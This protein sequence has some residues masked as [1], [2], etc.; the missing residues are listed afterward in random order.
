[1]SEEYELISVIM[2]V[3]KEPI[4]WIVKAV[5]SIL[6]QSYSNIELIVVVDNPNNKAAIDYIKQLGTNNIKLLIND[7]NIG[8][9]N[10]LNKALKLC[11]GKYIARM[12]ADDYSYPERIE[13]ELCFL[14]NNRLDIVGCAYE[15]IE[16]DNIIETRSNPRNYEYIRKV[17][18]YKNCMVHPSW[19]VKS[20]VYRD[21]DGYRY[22]D[23]CEDYDFLVRAVLKGYKLGNTDKILFQY[24][25]NKESISHLKSMKQELT[26]KYIA[27]YY[28]M[29]QIMPID[30][31]DNYINS[32]NYCNDLDRLKKKN[33]ID[34]QIYNRN[35]IISK[36]CIVILG[37]ITLYDFRIEKIHNQKVKILFILDRYK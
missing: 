24:R 14:K 9:V 35:N 4:Q 17:L 25:M 37:M 21:L 27:N 10:S 12:D 11:S 7:K 33:N 30:K 29:S 34:E 31:Y 23:A 1:M 16:N 19:L 13:E 5:D 6:N 3:Y 32:D 2:S 8:L 36:L 15:V 26:M 18:M 22:I 28:K 20:E